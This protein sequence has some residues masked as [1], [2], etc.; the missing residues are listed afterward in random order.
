MP[1]TAFRTRYGHYEFLV[2]PF[3]LTNA[4]VAFM[5]L[6][7]RVFK[8]FVDKFV[9][10]FIDDILIYS[11]SME[12]HENHLRLVLQLLQEKKLYAKLKKCELWLDSVAF[13]RHVVSKDGITVDPK[14]V[15]AVVE[16]NRPNS[17]TKVRSFLGLA[18]YYRRFVEGFSHLA[19]PLTRL[20][21]RELS[22]SG[23]ESVK[24]ASKN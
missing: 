1:K 17:V 14:K 3:G 23:P 19:M 6:M 13:L 24:K 11:K 5:D 15:E 2:M 22:L 4:P 9:A 7:N 16:W 10:V 8:P 21:Q 20:T 12:E 18:G